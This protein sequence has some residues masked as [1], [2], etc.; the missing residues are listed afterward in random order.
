MTQTHAGKY[1]C[2]CVLPPPLAM[3]GPTVGYED[4]AASH[5]QPLPAPDA[6]NYLWWRYNLAQ[7]LGGA[8]YS[9]LEE[10]KCP[11]TPAAAAAAPLQLA[12]NSSN[13]NT[14]DS[15]YW[16]VVDVRKRV[17][18]NCTD[19]II[20][21]A[22]QS[23]HPDCFGA[24]K[25]PRNVTSPCWIECFFSTLMGKTSAHE[26]YDPSHALNTTLLHGAFLQSFADPEHQG[27]PPV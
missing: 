14:G 18:K 22:V 3:C 6:P 4:V 26:V 7:Y 5:V 20:Q 9:F 19:A 17:R 21:A 24:C 25:Q 23:V 1:E 13:T 12:N 16:R 11:H 8:W 10:G 2:K 27:C 15:C